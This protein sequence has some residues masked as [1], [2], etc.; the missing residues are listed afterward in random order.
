VPIGEGLSSKIIK[1]LK[2]EIESNAGMSF[3]CGKF[4]IHKAIKLRFARKGYSTFGIIL[5]TLKIW[6]KND[7]NVVCYNFMQLTIGPVPNL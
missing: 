3:R 4:N 5:E 6:Q 1:E 2:G 7:I